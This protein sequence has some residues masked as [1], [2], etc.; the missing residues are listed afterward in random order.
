MIQ[1]KMYGEL[2][3]IE[4]KPNNGLDHFSWKHTFCFVLTTIKQW[5]DL[6]PIAIVSLSNQKTF[7]ILTIVKQLV[8]LAPISIVSL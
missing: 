4:W 3:S 6:A 5:L 8:D 1:I 2:C 7:F